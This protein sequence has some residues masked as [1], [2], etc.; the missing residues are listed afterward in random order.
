[1]LDMFCFIRHFKLSVHGKPDFSYIANAGRQ[2]WDWDHI[3]KLYQAWSYLMLLSY[4][5]KQI[6]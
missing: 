1:M 5:E 2:A 6:L 3:K 4:F